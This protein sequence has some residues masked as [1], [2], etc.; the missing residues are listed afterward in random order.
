[1]TMTQEQRW[2]VLWKRL[3]ARGD[4]RAV[5][6]D[7]VARYSEPHRAYH[8]LEHI[9]HCLDEFEQ[10]RHLAMNPDAVELALWYHDAIY[11]TKAKDSEERSATL[12]VE[13]AR[14]ASLPDSFGQSVANLIT[15]TKHAS[16]P[17]DP[18]VQLLVDIDLSILGQ[19]EDTFDEYERQVRKEYEWVAKDA[20]IAGRSAIL[21]SFLDRQTIYSTQFF[22][23]KYESQARANIAKS[24]ARL[25]A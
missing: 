8:T 18:D 3:G 10:V 15:A 5:Y 19:S 22:R 1:M 6:T 23:D 17:I 14:N 13:V 24:L 4:A 11:D 16:A 20:F 25:R 2:V 12:A 7:L 9:G 21:K